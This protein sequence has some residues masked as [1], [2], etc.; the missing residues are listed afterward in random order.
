MLE[1]MQKIRLLTAAVNIQNII[2]TLEIDLEYRVLIDLYGSRTKP[3][4]YEIQ[5]LENVNAEPRV[6]RDFTLQG[7]LDD[8][9][10]LFT[11]LNQTICQINNNLILNNNLEHNC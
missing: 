8:G 1:D 6:A 2:A 4:L 10:D 3:L 5:A 9:G 7:Q 11:S